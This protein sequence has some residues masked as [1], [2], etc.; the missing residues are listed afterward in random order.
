MRGEKLSDAIAY[1][2]LNLLKKDFFGY[3]GRN[4]EKVDLNL[5]FFMGMLSLHLKIRFPT[6]P[7]QPMTNS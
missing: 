7:M 6:F 5:R 2:K 4:T 3:I 1:D